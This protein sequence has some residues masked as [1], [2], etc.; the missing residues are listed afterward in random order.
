M[1]LPEDDVRRAAGEEVYQTYRKY[2]VGPAIELFVARTG[3][4]RGPS[5]G[6]QAPGV[7]ELSARMQEKRARMQPNLALFLSHLLRATG[8]YL[9]DVAALRATG[10]RVVVAVGAQSAGQFA[11]DTGLALAERLGTRAVTFPGGHSGFFTHPHAF[12]EKLHQVLQA[13]QP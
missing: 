1:L 12:A 11:H 13:N 9:P 8:A 2:G 3:L 10:A 6:E 4:N 5:E 7:E